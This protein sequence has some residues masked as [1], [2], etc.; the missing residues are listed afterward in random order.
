MRETALGAYAHQDL[1]FEKLVE[2][3]NPE[4]AL[5]HRPLFQVVFNLQNAPFELPCGCP[6]S[7][8]SPVET[9]TDTREVRPRSLL[10]R[11]AP[12]ALRTIAEYDAEL[13]EGSTVERMLGHYGCVLERVVERPGGA[14]V[15]ARGAGGVGASSCVGGVERDGSELPAGGEHRGALLGAGGA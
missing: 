7:T 3:L 6:G 4:R 13:F 15:G 12:P 8:L 9:A 5:S 11:D 2:E 14:G 1:P 10:D